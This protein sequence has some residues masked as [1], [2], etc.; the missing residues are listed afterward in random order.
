MLYNI[1]FKPH[2]RTSLIVK[3]IASCVVEAKNKDS[4]KELGEAIVRDE[5]NGNEYMTKQYTYIIE[6]EGN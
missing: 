6:K 1:K 2:R 3:K 5:Y 4:A